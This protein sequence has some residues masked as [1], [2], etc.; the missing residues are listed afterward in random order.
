MIITLL[1]IEQSKVVLG[2]QWVGVIVT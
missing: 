2:L 1:F